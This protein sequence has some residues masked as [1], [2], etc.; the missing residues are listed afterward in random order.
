MEAFVKERDF[1]KCVLDLCDPTGHISIH[2]GIVCSSSSDNALPMEEMKL[3]LS[4][5]D[6][7]LNYLSQVTLPLLPYTIRG[8]RHPNLTVN[9]NQSVRRCRQ[10][11]TMSYLG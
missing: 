4:V 3:Q 9:F 10:I 5:M 7:T 1:L 11:E 6:R 2:S 8:N